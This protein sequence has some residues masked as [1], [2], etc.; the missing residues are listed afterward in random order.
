MSISP[1]IR[2]GL[3]DEIGGFPAAEYTFDV[4]GADSPWDLTVASQQYRVPFETKVWVSKSSARILKIARTS[5][6]MPPSSRISEI[7]WSVVLQPVD[8]DGKTWLLPNT[9][10]YSVLYEHSNHR[11]WN[12]INF[13]DYHR[14]TSRSVIHF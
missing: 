10:E 1:T 7:Q 3:A 6:A 8:M 9:G 2:L 5:A 4:S 13:T 12:I 11:E 14:Y